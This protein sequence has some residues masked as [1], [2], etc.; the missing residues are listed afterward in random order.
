MRIL[1]WKICKS[2]ITAPVLLKYKT[3]LPQCSSELSEQ[4]VAPSH[5][6]CFKMQSPIAH[7]HS[8]V[9]LHSMIKTQMNNF[10]PYQYLY[11]FLSNS[12]WYIYQFIIWRTHGNPSHHCYRDNRILC[13]TWGLCRHTFHLCRKTVQYCNLKIRNIFT[14]LTRCKLVS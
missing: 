11:Q 3:R 4:S 7:F 12:R 10:S 13:H 6:N 5:L 2:L 14:E 9:S 1:L 8:I